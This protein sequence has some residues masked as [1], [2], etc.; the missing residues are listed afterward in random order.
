MQKSEKCFHI[1]TSAR[2]RLPL[3]FADAAALV[4]LPIDLDRKLQLQLPERQLKQRAFWHEEMA[5]LRVWIFN[6]K[7]RFELRTGE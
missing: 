2:P 3:R 1:G 5:G 4:E 6:I 7:L